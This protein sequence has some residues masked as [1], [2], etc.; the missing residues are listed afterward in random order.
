MFK[1]ILFATTASPVCDNA[2]KVAFDLELKWDAELIVFHVLGIPTHGFSPF[3][4]DV[5]TGG[6]ELADN[7]YLDWVKE[8]MKN[9]YDKLLQDAEKVTIEA[10]IGMPH[11]EILRK[12]RKENVDLIVMGAHTRPEDVGASRYRSVVGSTMQKVAKNA[13][14]PI[15]II[16]RPCTTCWKL[17]SNIVVAT[18]FSKASEAAFSWA[19]KLAKQ[20]N[21]NLHIFHAVDLKATDAGLIKAQ[22][23][24]EA[25]IQSAREKIENKYLPRL[26]GFEN[27]TVEIWE[28]APYI[29]I[30][31]F[32]RDRQ[33]DLIVMA[34]HAREI[35]PEL[36]LFGSTVEQVVL[37]SACPVA[38]V[39]KLDKA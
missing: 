13:R 26:K 3:V 8:E 29:E 39:N 14:C 10:A 12:A 33:A 18:D 28:G 25:C 20:V 1:K 36:A 38:S 22:E 23:D 19:C 9:T 37:R 31:K 15:A 4:T 30:L 7:D 21:A 6:N 5:R 2:A 17:F 34:H 27:H 24:I 11:R 16:S 32:A 35:D